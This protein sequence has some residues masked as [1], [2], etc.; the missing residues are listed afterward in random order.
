LSP[1]R[2]IIHT[3]QKEIFLKELLW[4]EFTIQKQKVLWW[5]PS[6]KVSFLNFKNKGGEVFD[7]SCSEGIPTV[8]HLLGNPL[9]VTN[10][11]KQTLERIENSRMLQK[12]QHLGHIE[13]IMQNSIEL[14][15]E[16][17]HL[18]SPV[19]LQSVKACGVT[20]ITSLLERFVF[21]S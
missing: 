1:T 14:K 6:T 7:L 12:E 8:A 21:L 3:F 16:S 4:E 17:T 19:D 2:E 13:E 5:F 18:L 20:F 10:S 11:V 15:K 9:N